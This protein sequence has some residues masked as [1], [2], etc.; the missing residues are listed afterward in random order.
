MILTNITKLHF[1]FCA[2][3]LQGPCTP[4]TKLLTVR[5]ERAFYLLVNGV[6]FLTPKINLLKQKLLLKV[7][8]IPQC[9]GKTLILLLALL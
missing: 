4:A 2:I 6:Y 9:L 8:G 3:I 5:F 1:A 7:L